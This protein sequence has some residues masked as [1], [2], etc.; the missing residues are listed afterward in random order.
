VRLI[1]AEV[2]RD[3]PSEAAEL[4]ERALRLGDPRR[5]PGCH[6]VT[7]VLT[8][9]SSTG[10]PS[11][12]TRRTPHAHAG[13]SDQTNMPIQNIVHPRHTGCHGPPPGRTHPNPSNPDLTPPPRHP[14]TQPPTSAVRGAASLVII[15]THIPAAATEIVR[16]PAATPPA[17]NSCSC[18]RVVTDG[19]TLRVSLF[20]P[21]RFTGRLGH[22]P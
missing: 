16:L 2:G 3:R 7:A 20:R 8:A 17:S 18:S 19:A 11:N 5:A 1:H 6:R 9:T 10:P 4:V 14:P 15:T 13:R 21:L 22:H 12:T